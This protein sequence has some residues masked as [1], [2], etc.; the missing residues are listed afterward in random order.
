MSKIKVISQAVS[1]NGSG[2]ATQDTP[3]ISGE[4]IKIV[5]DKGTV[6]GSSTVVTK[7]KTVFTGSIQ[8]QIDSYDINSGSV[9]RYPVTAL[10]GASAGD[11]KWGRFVVHDILNI[12]VSGGKASKAFTVHIYYK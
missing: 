5:Y 10:L 7:C 12:S 1:I 2:A 8:E 9:I 4:I 3:M 11:N 6:D